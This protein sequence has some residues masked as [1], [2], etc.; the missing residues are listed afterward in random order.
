MK[1]VLITVLALAV[2]IGVIAVGVVIMQRDDDPIDDGNST[3]TTGEESTTGP[4]DSTVTTEAEDTTGGDNT[5]TTGGHEGCVESNPSSGNQTT[6][7]DSTDTSGT[8]DG[9]TTTNPGNDNTMNPEDQPTQPEDTTEPDD[10]IAEPTEPAETIFDL[11]DNVKAGETL[12]GVGVYLDSNGSFYYTDGQVINGTK[13]TDIYGL[14][15]Y[16]FTGFQTAYVSNGWGNAMS[17]VTSDAYMTHGLYKKT[18]G[19]NGVTAYSMMVSYIDANIQAK[20][21]YVGLIYEGNNGP[22]MVVLGNK[23]KPGATGGI[24]IN[25]TVGGVKTTLAIGLL[26]DTSVYRTKLTIS[27]MNG[28]N[29]LKSYD[30][31]AENIEKNSI[32]DISNQLDQT[33]TQYLFF[34]EATGPLEAEMIN[35][36]DLEMYKM[37]YF[38]D[39]NGMVFQACLKLK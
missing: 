11:S 8:P 39:E 16:R 9:G 14:E 4:D 5:V 7:P 37:V 15:S 13:T 29:I 33:A 32:N 12:L 20:D 31:N 30:V 24:M 38:L 19:A 34:Y 35:A 23:L 28:F 26:S 25:T 10:D 27:S 21:L 22:Y 18:Q 17:Y 36:S 6:D 2:V 1:K 3:N